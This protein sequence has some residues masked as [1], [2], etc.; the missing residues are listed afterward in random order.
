MSSLTDGRLAAALKARGGLVEQV[1]V[2]ETAAAPLEAGQRDAVLAADAVT[3]ASASAARFLCDA[4]GEAV[5]PAGTRLIAMGP[6]SAAATRAAFGRV[7][8]E[9]AEPSLD[10][11]VAATV[12]A[13]TWDS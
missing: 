2:Y 6:E 3:F 1:A 7:D 12:Q 13:L 10:A 5:I 11:L 9:A 8:M 4:L